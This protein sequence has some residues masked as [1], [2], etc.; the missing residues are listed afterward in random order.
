MVKLKHGF[1]TYTE[2][3]YSDVMRLHLHHSSNQRSDL[4]RNYLNALAY[5]RLLAIANSSSS[6]SSSSPSV[7]FFF[8]VLM[9]AFS[10]LFD[11]VFLAPFT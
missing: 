7:I 9:S 4:L 11:S 8:K 2:T 1:I 10:S 6:S 3:F 5:I